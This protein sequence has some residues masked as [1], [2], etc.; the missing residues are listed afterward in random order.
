VTDASGQVRMRGIAP[1]DYRIFAWE[2]IEKGAWQDPTFVRN[3]ESSGKAIHINEGE[4]AST[5][6]SVIPSK[7]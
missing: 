3:H 4:K 2:D 7:P 6:I 1:G 5:E